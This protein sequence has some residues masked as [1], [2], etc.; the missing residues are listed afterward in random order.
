MDIQTALDQVQNLLDEERVEEAVQVID[1]LL[2]ADQADVIEALNEEHT[3]LLV[4][5]ITADDMADIFAEMEDYDAAELAEDFLP[6]ALAAIMDEM[7]PDDAADVLGDVNTALST[8]TLAHMHDPQPVEQLMA[9]P[10]DS[11]GGLMTTELLRFGPETLTQDIWAAIRETRIQGVRIPYV[12][13]V[14]ADHQLLGVVG[15]MD[16]ICAAGTEP[17]ETY[18][19]RDVLTVTTRDDRELAARLMSRY[20]LA[21]LPVLDERK[22]LVGAI[23]FDDALAAMEK[24]AAEDMLNRGAI[25]S[26]GGQEMARSQVLVRGPIWKTLRVRMPFL[27]ITMAGGLLAGG[28]ISAFEE[29]VQAVVA[30]A[31]FIPVVM[32]MGGNVGTQSSTIFARGTSLGQININRIGK[33]LLREVAVGL[34]MG[35]ILGTAG[36]LIAYIWQGIPEV[37]LVVGLSLMITMTMA[38]TLGFSIPYLLVKVGTDM[39]A[40]ADPI[41][42]TIKDVTGLL[43]YFGLAHLFMSALL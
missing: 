1:Q 8:S 33:V 14:N 42:T 11:A 16:L 10:D 39:A 23:T 35:L 29:A 26:F 2:P 34:G 18:M 15:P 43:I 40:G 25:S 17:L 30:L 3:Q 6:E 22:R 4:S 27:L 19:A 13:V 5:R 20:D 28:V 7:E 12:F 36:G 9:Y 24:E 41:I 21:A 32:D 37:G 31:I 38:A